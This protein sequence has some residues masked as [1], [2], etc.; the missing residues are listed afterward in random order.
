MPPRLNVYSLPK[1]A[2]PK[3]LADGT[4][5]VVDV[6]RAT[7]TIAYALEAGAR[8]VIPCREVE[9]ARALVARYS[10]EDVL[11]GGE[12]GG[13]M[14]EG[15][16]FGNSPEEYL[17]YR[18]EGKILIFTTTNG[19][20]AMSHAQAGKQ[21]YLGAFVNASA[22]VHKLLGRDSIHI[23]CA[24]TDGQFSEDDILL[25]GLLVERIQKLGGMVYEMNV[26]ATTAREFWLNSLAL[27]KTL[28]AEAI[29]P[30]CLAK[31]LRKSLGAKN[32]IAQGYDDDILAAAQIDR[33]RNVPEL[34]PVN[35]RV[36]L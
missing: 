33:F 21:I 11:L 16:D 29:E 27:P 3:D 6:L 32:L 36:M 14:I 17:D 7:T 9:E 8:E 30:E 20:Q 12:R 28:G 34:D 18:V 13:N 10:P 31:E 26:Q 35:F 25:A 22:V 19:T 23:L 2:D 4:V 5:V 15:F 24:G 1:F